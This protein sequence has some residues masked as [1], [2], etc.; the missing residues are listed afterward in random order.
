MAYGELIGHVTGDVTWPPKVKLVTPICLEQ[1]ISKT[2]GD[3]DSFSKDN[4]YEKANEVSNGQ[5]HNP[6]ML[7]AQF[8]KQLEMQ[9]SNNRYEYLCCEAV[10]TTVQYGRLS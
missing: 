2:A 3:R 10:R 5:T 6:S 8:Q 9:F 7:I 4:Q 1:N